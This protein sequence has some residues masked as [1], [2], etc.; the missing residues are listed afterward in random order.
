MI[1][2]TDFLRGLEAEIGFGGESDSDESD[3]S[4]GGGQP[5][6]YKRESVHLQEYIKNTSEISTIGHRILDGDFSSA[7]Q[8]SDE[9]QSDDEKQSIP[10]EFSRPSFGGADDVD[11]GDK[12]KKD[13]VDNGDKDKKDDVNN[14]D[15]DKKDDV[16][17][18]DDSK[19]VASAEDD[20][21][22]AS[23]D[24]SDASDNENDASDN[25]D[26]DDSKSVASDTSERKS[27]G[28]NDENIINIDIGDDDFVSPFPTYPPESGN[29]GK[30]IDAE[31]DDKEDIVYS[32][33]D[34]DDD[35][36]DVDS[37]DEPD[38]DSDNDKLDDI[39]TGKT[40]LFDEDD[41]PQP[42]FGGS[43]HHYGA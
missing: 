34:S 30:L 23:D 9:K 35:E 14:D 38:V 2:L 24:D 1:N 37:D 32:D 39:Q 10:D 15:K 6:D 4:L 12:D 11:N 36:P 5:E 28:D 40:G 27:K 17:S 31:D 33:L 8:R 7:F 41:D 29:N 13:D 26:S 18:D 21:S 19:S 22:D 43:L 3:V 25:D 20:D 16:E 42:K